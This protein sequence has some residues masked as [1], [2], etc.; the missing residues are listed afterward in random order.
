MIKFNENMSYAGY[1]GKI[2]MASKKRLR[3]LKISLLITY[4]VY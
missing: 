2:A 3:P 1:S 4:K